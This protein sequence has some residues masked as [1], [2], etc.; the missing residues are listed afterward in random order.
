MMMMMMM[1]M[2]IGFLNLHAVRIWKGPMGQ[3]NDMIGTG[4]DMI[5]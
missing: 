5:R 2:I 4:Y 3:I 1:M